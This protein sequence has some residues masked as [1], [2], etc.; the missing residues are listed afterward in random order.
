MKY[1]RTLGVS[2]LLMI[3]VVIIGCTQTAENA[4]PVSQG[5][6]NNNDNFLVY[7]DP[8]YKV[9]IEYP[10]SWQLVPTTDNVFAFQ[11]PK[12]SDTDLF[13]ENINLVMNDLSNQPLTLEAYK[14]IAV[15]SMQQTFAD[16]S[17]LELG[18][19]TLSG[20]PAYKIIFTGTAGTQRLKFLQV[21]TI[22]NDISYVLTFVAEDDAFTDYLG[23]V[24]KMVDSFVITG[25]LKSE[26]ENDAP[27]E[28]D[29]DEQENNNDIGLPQ[30][31]SQVDAAFVGSWR[32]FSERIF[33]DIGGAGALGISVTRNLELSSDGTWSFGDSAGTWTVTEITDEDWARWDIDPYGPTR[34]ITLS[35]WN[36]GVGDGPVEE[37]E[38][39][40]DFI[41]VVYRV[42][43]P[44]VENAGTVWLK[45]GQS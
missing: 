12:E 44:L 20:N 32:V 26:A 35:N 19:V 28:L 29:V 18:S 4:P 34:K 22:Q 33:Y 2:I 43:P 9:A 36:N 40:V 8:V 15:E 17:L 42:E 16:F 5:L 27:P 11:S 31:D 23:T 39:I 24:Q 21:F 38:G 30:L 6:R 41:W 45:F 37:D 25:D 10:E 1:Q 3:V 14:D 13:Q 7:E